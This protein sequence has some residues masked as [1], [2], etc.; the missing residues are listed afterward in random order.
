MCSFLF[1][2]F[3]EY[4][5]IDSYLLNMFSFQPDGFSFFDIHSRFG[6]EDNT[7]SIPISN[8]KIPSLDKVMELARDENFSNFIPKHR[9]IATYLINIFMGKTKNI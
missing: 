6:G 5:V 4:L 1:H 9:E 2:Y 3:C 7:V 8:V